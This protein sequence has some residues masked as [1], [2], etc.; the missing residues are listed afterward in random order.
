[1]TF[2]LGW[3]WT[4]LDLGHSNYTSNILHNSDRY[5]DGVNRN[6]IGYNLRVIDRLTARPSTFDDL[7]YCPIS[8]SQ[9][10]LIKYLEYG[11][12]YNV[13]LKGGQIA[14]HQWAFYWH[15]DLWPWMTLNCPSLDN[16]VGNSMH[17]ADTRFIERISCFNK[18]LTRRWDTRTWRVGLAR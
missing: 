12:R 6:R 8:R 1:M 3:P 16:G 9:D 10:F 18:K 7:D 4:L 14:N 17:W 11:D 2:D 13:G 5:D 15:H